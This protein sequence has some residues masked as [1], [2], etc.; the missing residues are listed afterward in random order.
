MA[1][2]DPPLID[3]MHCSQEQQQQQ[4]QQHGGWHLP[5]ERTGAPQLMEHLRHAAQYH[6]YGLRPM[7]SASERSLCSSGGGGMDTDLDHNL[8]SSWG[9]ELS[10]EGTLPWQEMRHGPAPVEAHL[11]C[12]SLAT[13][14]T[15]GGDSN[16]GELRQS[17]E[18]LNSLDGPAISERQTSILPL[19]AAAHGSASEL[20]SQ[21]GSPALG[22]VAATPGRRLL[23]GLRSGGAPGSAQ[24]RGCFGCTSPFASCRGRP[25]DGDGDEV[26]RRAGSTEPGDFVIRS[27]SLPPGLGRDER[28][29]GGRPGLRKESLNRPPPSPGDMEL[30]AR[31]PAFSGLSGGGALG[32]SGGATPS[33]L[34]PRSAAGSEGSRSSL[35]GSG[36]SLPGRSGSDGSAAV[37][38]GLDGMLSALKAVESPSVD[39]LNDMLRCVARGLDELGIAWID[40]C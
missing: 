13:G 5:S 35:R 11:H 30:A 7:S 29:A 22:A 40:R 18:S 3:L 28:G 26:I 10:A 14:G 39:M 23:A 2:P 31:Q 1:A 12:P 15:A 20:S 21:L 38:A 24:R 33:G 4:Q 6:H 9:S 8:R 37:G 19:R 27:K 34:S 17:T 16:T 32:N 25:G 36:G